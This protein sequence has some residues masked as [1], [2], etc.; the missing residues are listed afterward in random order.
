MTLSDKTYIIRS[1]LTA[2]NTL[3]SSVTF[4]NCLVLWIGFPAQN[5]VRKEADLIL[6]VMSPTIL[7]S[8]NHKYTKA[9]FIF[10]LG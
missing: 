1:A 4:L 5:L 8:A 9:S 7:K 10:H 2:K 3:T 6:I